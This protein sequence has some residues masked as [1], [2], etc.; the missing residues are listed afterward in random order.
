MGME[1]G[2]HRLAA[3]RE[4]VTEAAAG[5]AG[6]FVALPEGSRAAEGRAEAGEAVVEPGVVAWAAAHRVRAA[7]KAAAEVA[8][9]VAARAAAVAVAQVRAVATEAVVLQAGGTGAVGTSAEEG[10]AVWAGRVMEWPPT[11]T[12]RCQPIS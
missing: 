5:A 1:P 12:G 9:A 6:P 10:A 3:A 2:P 11:G 4:A 8:V 7:A